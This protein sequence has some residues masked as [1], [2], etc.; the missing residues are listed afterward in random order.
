[1]IPLEKEDYNKLRPNDQLPVLYNRELN[2]MMP[3]NYTPDHT[4]LLVALFM[5]TLTIFFAW[6]NFFRRKTR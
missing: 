6:N 4:N 5:W 3:E 1:M 2:D